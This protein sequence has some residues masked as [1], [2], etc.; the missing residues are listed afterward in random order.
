MATSRSAKDFATPFAIFR[1]RNAVDYSEDGPM[2]SQPMT[3]REIEGGKRL[4]EVGFMDGSKVKLMFS[5]PGISLTYAW[6]KSGFP[7]P[8]HSHNTDC[9][10]FI[11]AGSL[12]IGTEELGPGDGFFVGT[13]VPYTYVPGERGVEVLE[14]RTSNAYDIRLLANSEAWWDKALTNLVAAKESWPEEAPPSGM[15]VG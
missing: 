4:R 5:R 13:D 2:T 3:E 15:E 6:F 10:Y 9:L 8:R 11:V 12:R 1:A 14:F 7:L